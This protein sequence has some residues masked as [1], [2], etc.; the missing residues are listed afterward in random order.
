M[1][2]TQAAHRP[3]TFYIRDFDEN[4]QPRLFI[5]EDPDV[6]AVFAQCCIVMGLTFGAVKE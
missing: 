4:D 6:I 5:T 3:L 2:A 1:T